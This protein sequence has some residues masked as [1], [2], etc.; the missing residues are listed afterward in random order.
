MKTVVASKFMDLLFFFSSTWN[1]AAAAV[2]YAE[3]VR[4]I[5]GDRCIKMMC[6][7]LSAKLYR[8]D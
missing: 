7:C 8:K 5:G 1:W 3:D 2:Y 4:I 6:N